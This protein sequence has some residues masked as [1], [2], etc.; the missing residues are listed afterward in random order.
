MDDKEKE[1]FR[2]QLEM[3]KK[4]LG[5]STPKKIVQENKTSD[6]SEKI[7]V[8]ESTEL[9]KIAKVDELLKRDLSKDNSNKEVTN[10]NSE[11]LKIKDKLK[12]KNDQSKIENDLKNKETK[13]TFDNTSTTESKENKFDIIEKNELKSNIGKTSFVNNNENIELNQPLENLKNESTEKLD[14]NKIG[15][16][17]IFLIV[18]LFLY[19]WRVKISN[20]HLQNVVHSCN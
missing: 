19:A 1:R 7:I 17:W 11:I 18:V 6:E 12:I 4:E 16:N 8:K 14:Q 10:F 2:K 20:T 15:T 13:N 5:I 3:Y 9:E